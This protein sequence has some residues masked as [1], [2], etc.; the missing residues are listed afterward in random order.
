[1]DKVDVKV[2][3]KEKGKRAARRER[4]RIRKIMSGEN[5][6]IDGLEDEILPEHRK[7]GRGPSKKAAHSFV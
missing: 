2:E 1:M 3:V 6:P 4:K 5:I 7:M